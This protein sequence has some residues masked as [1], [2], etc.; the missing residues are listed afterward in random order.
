MKR[1]A[2]GAAAAAI[3]AL[4]AACNNGASPGNGGTR[5]A[6]GQTNAPAL[7]A[8]VALRAGEWELTGRILS[9]EPVQASPEIAARLRAQPIPPAETKRQC[10]T[11]G[12]VAN[13]IR[14]YRDMTM[15]DQ[16]GSSC[17]EGQGTFADGR[18]RFTLVCRNPDQTEVRQAVVGTYTPESLQYAISA[19]GTAQVPDGETVTL[20]IESTLSSRRIGDCPSGAN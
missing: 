19:N 2:T 16:P 10:L 8:P 5:A 14:T 15:A 12:Q 9:I 13:P 1:G 17:G 7:P 20:R 18:I 4:L 6:G 11:A 3:A